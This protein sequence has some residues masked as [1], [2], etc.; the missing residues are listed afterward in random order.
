MKQKTYQGWVAV[1]ESGTDYEADL[2]RHRLDDSGIP[3]V[4][5][6]QRDHAFNLTVGYLAPVLVL[7]QPDRVNEAREIL[8]SEPFSD[9]ELGRIALAADPSA[10]AAH[11][12]EQQPR[13]DSGAEAIR[14]TAPGEES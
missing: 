2:V 13:L 3:S 10:P 8:A 14:F 6:T 1:F 11:D 5:L 4:V 12:K 9:D 7:V